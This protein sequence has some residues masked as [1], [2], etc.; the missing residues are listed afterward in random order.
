VPPTAATPHTVKADKAIAVPRYN[1]DSI[2]PAA[3]VHASVDDLAKW[4]RLQLGMGEFG[5]KRIYS[6]AQGR[7]MWTPQTVISFAPNPAKPSLSHFTTYALG[8]TAGDY[9]GR[10][11]IEHGGSIDGMFSKIVLLPEL[12]AGVVALTNSDTPAADL[13]CNRAIDGLLGLPLRDRSGEGLTRHNAREQAT[14]LQAERTES[15]RAKD[16][17]PSLPLGEYAGKYG[18][19]L[20]GDVVVSLEDDKLVLRFAPAPTFVADLEPW[21]HDTFRVNWRTLNPYIPNGWATFVLDRRG[22]SAEVRIDCP[23]N[24]FDFTELELK[25]RP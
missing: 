20:Y 12:K 3:G 5:G 22:K 8:W 1:A 4:M 17:K 23:N 2:A 24:D 7:A 13:M 9:N 11:R 25:R 19:D 21:Q 18:G 16:S 10:L 14:K 6:A 15:A